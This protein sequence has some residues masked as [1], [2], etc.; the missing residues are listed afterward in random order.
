MYNTKLKCT[1]NTPEIFLETDEV[2]EADKKFI[3][4]VIYRQELLNIFGIEEYNDAEINKAIYEL[5]ENIRD[6]V[7]LKE[8]MIKLSNNFMSTDE[9]V[10]LIVLFSYDYLYLTHDCICEHLETGIIKE[11][12]ICKLNHAILYF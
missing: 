3:R 10:G 6:C 5:Y 7:Q 12:T 9:K 8:C 11:A 4:D 2:S 1:Y